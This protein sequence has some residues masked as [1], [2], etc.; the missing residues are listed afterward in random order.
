MVYISFFFSKY[1]L[2]EITTPTS[3]LKQWK[4]HLNKRRLLQQLLKINL[5]FEQFPSI[6]TSCYARTNR[7]Y[8]LWGAFQHVTI[9]SDYYSNTTVNHD[10]F[11]HTLLF[12]HVLKI[13]DYLWYLLVINYVF[14]QF[15]IYNCLFFI[16][17]F[18]TG[19]LVQINIFVGGKLHVGRYSDRDNDRSNM[20][21]I[22]YYISMLIRTVWGIY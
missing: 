13:L 21:Q 16:W 15:N 9:T 4:F 3:F 18:T 11:L 19:K 2:N 10:C 20:L 22:I 6:V 17:D 12:V 7:A 1:L 8:I 5:Q 14:F